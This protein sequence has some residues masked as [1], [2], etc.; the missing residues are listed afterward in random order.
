MSLDLNGKVTI[1]AMEI[2]PVSK[3]LQEG[4]CTVEAIL[5]PTILLLNHKTDK[6]RIGNYLLC[7]PQVAAEGSIFVELT[8]EDTHC[9]NKST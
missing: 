5:V 1:N 7:N 6:R 4:D 3:E 2:K 9:D 8:Q